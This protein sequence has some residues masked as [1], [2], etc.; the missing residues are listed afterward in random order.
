MALLESVGLLICEVFFVSR[1]RDYISPIFLFLWTREQEN[2]DSLSRASSFLP[3]QQ[4]PQ[5]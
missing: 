1:S 5:T 3:Y 2:F 4:V